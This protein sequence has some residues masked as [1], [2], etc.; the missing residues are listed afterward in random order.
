MPNFPN[1][2]LIMTH[3]GR[4]YVREFLWFQALSDTVRVCL[5]SETIEV[6]S[7]K[8]QKILDLYMSEPLQRLRVYFPKLSCL[9][10]DDKITVLSDDIEVASADKTRELVDLLEKMPFDHVVKRVYF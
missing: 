4:V 8:A 1:D 6:S 9:R 3:R 7:D 2:P 10:L 5:G